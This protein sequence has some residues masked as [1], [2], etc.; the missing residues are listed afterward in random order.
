MRSL[1]CT[2]TLAVCL[3]LAA[4]L[5]PTRNQNTGELD[6]R[7]AY[8]PKQ[9][10]NDIVSIIEKKFQSPGDPDGRGIALSSWVSTLQL[11]RS[12]PPA[13]VVTGGPN[14]PDNGATGNRDIWI[15]RQVDNHATLIFTGGGFDI[16]PAKT[17]HNGMLDL[18]TSWNTGSCCG[19]NEVY[20]FDGHQYKSE[21]C[22]DYETDDD[23]N[24][25]FGPHR[26][27]EH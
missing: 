18:E 26:K 5:A 25:K 21:Y 20:R 19:G 16:S 1:Y 8:L 22:Y 24:V 12:G 17:Y 14:D 15:F 4:Q 13:I 6:L 11:S 23:G 2:F 27:C 7:D 3:P 9:V 10:E